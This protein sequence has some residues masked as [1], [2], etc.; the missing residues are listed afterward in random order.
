MVRHALFMKL[1]ALLLN[2]AANREKRRAHVLNI[3]TEF[4][5]VSCLFVLG[6]AFCVPPPY[7]F[8]LIADDLPSCPAKSSFQDKT[9][10][11]VMY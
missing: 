2:S 1:Q 9:K 6:N 8:I 3:N 5:T 7:F 10:V 4:T 11:L